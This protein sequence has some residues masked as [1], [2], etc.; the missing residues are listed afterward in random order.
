MY[1]GEKN[2]QIEMREHCCE[3]ALINHKSKSSLFTLHSSEQLRHQMILPNV[4]TIVRTHLN[5][6]FVIFLHHA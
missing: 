6:S 4:Y 5:E 1:S 2:T 3:C